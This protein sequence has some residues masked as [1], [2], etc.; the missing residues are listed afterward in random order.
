MK[1]DQVKA[2]KTQPRKFSGMSYREVQ[3]SNSMR[4]KHINKNQQIWLKKNGYK[5]VGWDYVIKLYQ[6]I[7]DLLIKSDPDELSLEELFLNV[8]RLGEKYQTKEEI[9]D[10][11]QEMAKIAQEISHLIDEQFPETDMEIIDFS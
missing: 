11:H 2:S 6:K 10:F 3:K 8:D 7:N 5:N 9:Q 4:R 1:K